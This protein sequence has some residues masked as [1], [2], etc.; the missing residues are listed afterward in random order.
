[1]QILREIDINPT[2]SVLSALKEQEF[3][4]IIR[5]PFASQTECAVV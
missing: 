3:Y 4:K 2:I 1:M 5:T